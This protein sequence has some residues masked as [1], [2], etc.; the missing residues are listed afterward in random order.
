MTAED[1]VEFN[2]LGCQ[3]GADERTDRLELRGGPAFIFLR[4]EPEYRAGRRNPRLL[5]D[6]RNR[7]SR[8]LSLATSYSQPSIQNDA[9]LNHLTPD[10]HG[11]RALPR[12][13]PA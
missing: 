3:S 5:R 13:E 8:P 6:R 7:Q 4:Q 2:L 9:P 1:P 10:E 11:Y 12:R